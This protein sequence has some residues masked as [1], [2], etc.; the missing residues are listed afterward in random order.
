MASAPAD[1][2]LETSTTTGTGTLTLAGAVTGYQTFAAVGNS[3]TT[4]Y[5]IFGVDADGIPTGEWETG[6]GTYTSSGTTLA[7][8][9]VQASSNSN[10]AVNFS[11]GT[12]YVAS[13]PTVAWLAATYAPF[14]FKGADIASA[15]TTDIGAATGDFVDIT[16][17]TT[18]T[19][20][21]TIAAGVER[22]V[23]FTGAL[24]LTHNGTSLIL[25]GA[26]NIT[27]AANDRAIFRSLGSGNWLCVTYVKASGAAVLV[28]SS[29]VLTGGVISIGT[30]GAGVATTFSITAGTG[31]IVDNTVDPTT[32]TPVSWTA[33]TDIAVTNILTQIITYVA[34]DSGGNV[35]QSGTD[36]TPAQQRE[37]VVIGIAVHSNQTTVNAV[38]QTQVVAYAPG[39]QASDLMYGLGIFNVTGNVFTAN[40]ANLKLNKSAGS[41]FRRGSNYTTLSDNPH[42]ITTGSLTQAS[43]RMQNQTGAGSASTTDVDVA[44]YDL[45]GVTTAVSPSTRFTIL[46]VFLFQSNLIAVQRGQATY[47][48]LA[49]AKA[50]IQLE[51]YVTNSILAANG[52]LRGFIVAQ[53]SATS[54]SDASKVFFIEAG[55]FGGSSGVGGLSVSTLQNVYDNS[56]SPEILTDATRL[57]L[58]LKRGSGADT[59]VLIEGQNGNGDTTFSVTGAGVVTGTWGGAAVA[60][61]N[62]GTGATTAVGGADALSTKGADIASATT[63]DLSTATG[64][65]VDITGT[66]TIT[67]LG[68]LAAG[69]ERTVRFTGALTLTHNATSLILPGAANITTA[70]DD[71]A[72]FRSLGSGN[73]LCVSYNKASGA[74]VVSSG[75]G[76]TNWSE[77]AGTYSSKDWKRFYPVSGTN[78]NAVFSPLG[79]GSI[80]AQ[81]PDG[82]AAGGNQ[83]GNNAVDWQTKR[84]DAQL[85]ASG[86]QSVVGGGA[87]NKASGTASVVAG[88]YIGQAT[89]QWSSV[90]GGAYG[91]ATAKGATVP[92]GRGCV[93]DGPY[94]VSAGLFA[95]ARSIHGVSV[96]ASGRFATTG[97]AQ[98]RRVILRGLTTDATPKVLTSDAGAAGTTNQV[99]LPNN[100]C[101]QFIA[102]FSAHRTDSVGTTFGAV[103]AGTISRGANAGTTALVGSIT[104]LH[105][106]NDAGASSWTIAL[107]ADTSNGCLAATFTGEAAK[108]IRSALDVEMMEVTS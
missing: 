50:A 104:T 7:R 83:R 17:T 46:R 47:V 20:L 96:F 90:G 63:T 60:V 68:T 61:A 76:L 79:T 103:F 49:E 66:T 94:A 65:F 30:G 64:D 52:L 24:T 28:E 14:P 102:K 57:G 11:A 21:G 93:A 92:G 48:S 86:T 22:T 78:V 70:A 36:W 71:R 72:I 16:G 100:S 9:T 18:I 58:T 10:N 99:I 23:R 82:T 42:I 91:S 95:T 77:S 8:T 87:Y 40:G 59:D 62:G 56:S 15:T 1:R 89:A 29:G 2:V 43:L 107:T 38:N 55:R 31:Q 44:N 32:V 97:D 84:S 51:T 19:G 3:N 13:S 25:P 67:G 12:K 5:C 98:T 6:I 54:L 33:K 85:I 27:T 37:Y 74:A 80:Q 88:G 26:A 34:I 39:A 108:T 106:A 105:S 45:A 75:G 35:V 41:L 81:I 69:I 4:P 53:A 101:F 73:W